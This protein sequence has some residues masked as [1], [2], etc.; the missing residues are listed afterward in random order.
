[1]SRTSSFVAALAALALVAACGPSSENNPPQQDAGGLDRVAQHDGQQDGQMDSPVQEDGN[2][3]EDANLQDAGPAQLYADIRYLQQDPSLTGL[4]PLDSRVRIEGAIVMAYDSTISVFFLQNATGPKEYSGI[5]AR[6][7]AVVTAAAPAVGDTVTFEGTLVQEARSCDWDAGV[8]PTR[9]AVK[10][11]TLFTKG[12]A[13]TV[14][15]PLDVTGGEVLANTAKYDGVLLHLT[16]SPLTVAGGGTTATTTPLSNGLAVYGQFYSPPGIVPS[17]TVVTTCVGILDIYNRLWELYP[18]T[19]ADLVFQDWPG[20][21][22][23]QQDG[24]TTQQD[25]S[26]TSD[27]APCGTDTVVISQI[28]GGGGNADAVYKNDF[29]EL[30][31]RGTASVDLGTWSIQYSSAAGTSWATNKINLTGKSIAAGAYLLVQLGSGGNVGAD[32]PV[33]PDLTSSLNISASAGKFAL[34]KSQTGLAAATCPTSTD[35]VDLVGYG[36]SANC[37]ETAKAPAGANDMAVTRKAA[38]CQD[39]NDNGFD[40]SAVAP[41]PRHSGTTPA[42]CTCN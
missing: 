33:T 13:G 1:M 42:P 9:H 27:A 37:F 23:I 31:N 24:S 8:C 26:T 6:R 21:G 11:I 19:S 15:T 22:G 14:P 39:Y 12:A 20:D 2:T 4:A 41:A 17:G 40:F 35:I 10:D 25:G 28:Y 5:L 3:Q 32:L 30:F 7:N 16:D 34:V 38:G 29:I 18:R 36:T